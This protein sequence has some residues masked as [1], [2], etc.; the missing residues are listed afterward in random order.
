MPGGRSRLVLFTGVEPVPAPA[1][2]AGVELIGEYRGSGYRESPC[3]V[4]RG[5]RTVEMSPLLF[6]ICAAIDGKR[7]VHEVAAVVSASCGRHA[8]AA[9]IEYLIDH[10]LQPLSVLAPTDPVGADD[11]APGPRKQPALTLVIHRAL[12]SGAAVRR[13]VR[14][15]QALFRPQAVTATLVALLCMDVWLLRTGRMGAGVRSLVVHPEF[16]VLLVVLTLIGAAFHELGHATACGYGGAE[17]GVVGVGLY[18]IWPVFYNDLDDSYRLDRSGR[19]RADLGGVYFNA[20]FAIVLGAAHLLTG[21]LPLA[22]AVVMQHVAIVHQFLPFV[23]LDGYYVVSDLAGVPDL[24]GRIRPILASLLPGP[25][26]AA[27]NQLT[28]RARVL[29]TAWV[30]VTV[31]VLLAVLVLLLGRLPQLAPEVVGSIAARAQALEAA[32]S[33]GAGWAALVH[34]ARLVVVIIPPIGIALTIGHGVRLWR[35]RRGSC[36]SGTA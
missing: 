28:R 15:L 10:K 11:D 34:G 35:A 19:L 14:P 24:F 21:F 6:T 29:V 5:G 27:V 26:P 2:A 16:A 20:I 23:R 31:A 33:H 32:V 13:C 30:L 8:S 1:L 17:P 22:V 3:L 12:L 18:L 7:S 9:D 25:V 36:V 4:R